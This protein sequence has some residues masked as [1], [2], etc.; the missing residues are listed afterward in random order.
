MFAK[1]V[2][3]HLWGDAVLITTYLINMMPSKVL[4]FQTPIGTLKECYPHL[5]VFG[6][7]PLEVF[8]SSVFV[9]VPNKDRSKL[10]LKAIKCIFLGYSPTQKGY[11]CY[12]PPS[13]REFVTINEFLWTSIVLYKDWP[14][15]GAKDQS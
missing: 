15:R 9:H 4:N 14:S 7:L 1:N 13:K 12:H 8:G 5:S 11:K 3:K 10:D 2:L 6:S